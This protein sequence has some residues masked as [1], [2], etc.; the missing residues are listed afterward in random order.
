MIE[1]ACKIAK[2]SYVTDKEI[3]SKDKQALE[4]TSALRVLADHCRSA[5]FLIADGALPANEGRGYVLRRILRRAIRYGR[6]LSASQSFLPGM[7]EA[8]IDSMGEF[9]P[10]LRLRRDHVLNTIRDEE[11]RFIATLDKG[12]SILLEE[13]S[14]ART[15]GLKELSGEVVFKMYDTFGFP[16]DLTRVIANE[17]GIEVNENAFEENCI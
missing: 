5:S 6:K 2:I 10:E 4:Q 15:K 1:R 8:L 16:A 11:D 17:N 14:R 9:Y 12:T 7:A 3:L 13:I